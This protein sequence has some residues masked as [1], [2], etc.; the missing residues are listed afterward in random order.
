MILV[1]CDR[2]CFVIYYVSKHHKNESFLHEQY[3][4]IEMRKE[5]E[6]LFPYTKGFLP[7]IIVMDG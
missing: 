6:Q 3:Q 2:N 5:F 7:L 1:L 4:Y